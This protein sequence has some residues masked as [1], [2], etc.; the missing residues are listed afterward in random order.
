MNY[1]PPPRRRHLCPRLAAYPRP[2]RQHRRSRKSY[3]WNRSSS[4]SRKRHA[5][6]MARESPGIVAKTDVSNIVQRQRYAGTTSLVVIFHPLYRRTSAFS[7]FR[8]ARRAIIGLCWINSP[9]DGVLLLFARK[10][11][12]SPRGDTKKRLHGRRVKEKKS[13]VLES[14]SL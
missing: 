7:L 8:I 9:S 14:S 2:C 1:D 3:G 6:K 12:K 13:K 11:L 4:F 5:G 10:S